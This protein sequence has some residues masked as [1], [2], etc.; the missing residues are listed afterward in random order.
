MRL[1]C[2]GGGQEEGCMAPSSGIALVLAPLPSATVDGL[3]PAPMPACA[4][5]SPVQQPPKAL[6]RI[7]PPSCGAAA[8]SSVHMQSH[9]Q[10]PHLPEVQVP[11]RPFK[12]L[13]S[14][15]KLAG[16]ECWLHGQ[17]VQTCSGSMAR[18]VH[19]D[20]RGLRVHPV[21]AT[22]PS[23]RRPRTI[24]CCLQTRQHLQ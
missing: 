15:G 6:L 9:Q 17:D 5:A 3:S 16:A 10:E 22:L 7:C 18:R 14:G 24:C 8:S 2:E 19:E 11:T 4:L 1:R 13:S 12:P 20:G 23:R 21:P